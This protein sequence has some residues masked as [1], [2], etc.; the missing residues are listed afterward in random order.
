MNIKPLIALAIALMA[1]APLSTA[2]RESDKPS[3]EG[4]TE[5]VLTDK[6]D[7]LAVSVDVGS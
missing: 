2:M 7:A 4:V 5:D 6:L 1:L 3:T